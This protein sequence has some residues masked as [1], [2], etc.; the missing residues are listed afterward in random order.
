L[1]TGPIANDSQITHL[2]PD[3]RRSLLDG[4]QALKQLQHRRH[5]YPTSGPL[6][7][8][9]FSRHCGEGFSQ[10]SSWGR[11][12]RRRLLLVLPPEPIDSPFGVDQL[13]AP[14]KERVALGTDLYPESEYGGPGVDH[15]ATR[16]CDRGQLIVRVNAYLHDCPSQDIPD[17]SVT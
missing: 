9:Y 6:L 3:L 14:G 13:L 16:A 11:C 5:S 1:E 12:V 8:G 17:F 10:G 7:G 15:F 2:Q 4:L